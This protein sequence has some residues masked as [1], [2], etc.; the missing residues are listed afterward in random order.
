M[1]N[2]ITALIGEIPVYLQWIVAP[3]CIILF[4]F[5]SHIVFE[6]FCTFFQFFGFKG[7]HF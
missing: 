3:C 1:V 5:I 7:G 2:A 4:T 6:V